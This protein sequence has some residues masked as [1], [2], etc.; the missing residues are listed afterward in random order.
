MPAHKDE[1]FLQLAQRL[2][3]TEA[4]TLEKL[5]RHDQ[6]P[7]LLAY[8][9]EDKEFYLVQDFIEGHSLRDELLGKR[10]P[11]SQVVALLKD[12]LGI[13][14]FIHSYG[15]IHRDIKPSNI[16]RRK[17]DGRL[18]LIDFGAVKQLHTQIADA[19]EGYTIGIGTSGFA[20]PEQLMG[21]P[22]FSSDIYALGIVGIQ[23]VISSRLECP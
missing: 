18:V 8:F 9:Q 4:E 10:L 20:P 12:I 19:V 14:D 3:N 23:A 13:L 16:I 7:Q 6:I 1:D 2:F 22:G 17:W 21:Q 11:E 5:G 15:V